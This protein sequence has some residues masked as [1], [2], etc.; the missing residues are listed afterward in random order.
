L[1]RGVAPGEL[2]LRLRRGGDA[3]RGVIERSIGLAQEK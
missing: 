3:G 1:A 2:M